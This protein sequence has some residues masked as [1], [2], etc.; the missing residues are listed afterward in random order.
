MTK[1]ATSTSSIAIAACRVDLARTAPTELR[2]VPA[3]HFRARDGRPTT[4][5]QGWH[6]DAK[7][8]ERLIAAARTR[9]DDAVIDYEHQTLH[10]ET[11]GKPAPAA[12]WFS[13]DKLEWR[14][15][16]LYA[17][18]VQW[19]DAAKA[20]IESG[21]YRYLSPVIAYH[22]KTGDVQAVT[23]AALTNYAAIDGLDGLS[24]RAAA[25][26]DFQSQEET[27]V[28][29]EDLINLLGLAADATDDAIAAALKALKESADSVTALKA[30][31]AELKTK[32]PDTQVDPA[33][34]VPIAQVE[35]LK[36]QIA[37]LSAKDTGRD[38]EALVKQGLADGKLLAAQEEW[39]REL[40]TKD[41][42]ALK[43]YLDKTP[44]IAAL[45]GTQTGGKQPMDDKGNAVLTE[46]QLAICKATG[47]S[48]EDYKK[49]LIKEAV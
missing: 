47:V 43:A 38:V 19:T 21:E 24:A 17:T 1:Q 10:T 28:K 6:L 4:I 49:Q 48:P 31:V 36:T 8:A 33:K 15:D 14:P 35:A 18:D 37:E 11:N 22:P 20:A 16:G 3:G 2:L 46:S 32:Q 30:E 44:P 5:A 12:G 26:F 13:P 25:R 29:R 42:A 23:M 41:V 45:K 34:Y 9:Q 39:A 40:G 27:L 7:G